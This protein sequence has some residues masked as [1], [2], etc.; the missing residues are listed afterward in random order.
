MSTI[1]ETTTRT[2]KICTERTWP[3]P[4]EAFHAAVEEN[5]DNM[6]MRDV[7]N[8]DIPSDKPQ[9]AFIFSKLWRPGRTLRIAFI[10]DTDPI[11]RKKIEKYA[12]KW[13]EFVN[14]KF[15]FVEGSRGDIRI[16]T[17][18]DGSWSYIGTDAKLIPADEPTMNYG[19]LMPDTESEEYSR[20]V[21]H[22]FGHA[23]GAIHEHM[24]PDA[25]IPW[26]KPKVYAYYAQTNG[27]SKEDVDNN[28]FAKYDRNQ[29]NMSK[30]DKK[31]IMHYAV[32]NKL[33]IGN[34]QV[35]WNTVLSE[36]DKKFARMNYA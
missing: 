19:W 36:N 32:P 2:I 6:M 33:T 24:H 7:P 31:S 13:L 16:A 4:A 3:N 30:Y 9:I 26:D 5:P 1:Q 22:E 34:F 14:L 27:W 10:G 15:Q 28:I 23:L 20:V 29:L 35:G 17:A 12:K 25:G 18:D 21:L 11:V 8:M